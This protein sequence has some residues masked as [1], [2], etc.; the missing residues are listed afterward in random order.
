MK[1]AEM[2]TY[3]TLDIKWIRGTTTPFIVGATI[4]NVPIVLDDI[5]LSVWNKGGKQLAF[6]L[7]LADNEGTGPG[8]VHEETPGVF[9]FEPTAAQTRSLTQTPDDGT[10]GKNR[11][12]VETRLGAREDVRLMGAIQGIGGI[13]DDEEEIS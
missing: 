11:Y 2:A 13:N 10:P 1:R 5:R 8:T 12:E 3:G 9:V 6:R 7:T 4:D